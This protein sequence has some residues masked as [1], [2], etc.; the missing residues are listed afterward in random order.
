MLAVLVRCAASALV[1]IALAPAAQAGDGRPHYDP[2]AAAAR[3]QVC[4]QAELRAGIDV[5]DCGRSLLRTAGGA[6]KSIRTAA[7]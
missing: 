1:A 3:A 7:E 4:T 2:Y 5:R 6:R